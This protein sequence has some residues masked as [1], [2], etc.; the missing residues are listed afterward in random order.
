MIRPLRQRHRRMISVLG[1]FL[2]VALAVGIAARKPMPTVASLP[3]QLSGP[4]QQFTALKWER[5][6]LFT[7]TPMRVRLLR[8]VPK[9]GRSGIQFSVGKEFAKPDLLVYWVA[10]GT[11][12]T[13]TIPDNAF[14]LGAPYSSAALPLPAEANAASGVLVLYSL[15][16][17]EII[18]I[19]NAFST[20]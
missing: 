18:E 19:S 2:P 1:V 20:Q 3:A 11:K 7:K 5:D 16:D 12:V 6:D 9:G 17:H 8:E 14:L 13:D 4:P 15:A 10:A